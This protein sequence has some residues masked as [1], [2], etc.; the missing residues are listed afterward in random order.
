MA[1][2]GVGGVV[3]SPSAACRQVRF[4]PA[5]APLWTPYGD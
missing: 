5:T 3:S 4:Y 2:L 1:A